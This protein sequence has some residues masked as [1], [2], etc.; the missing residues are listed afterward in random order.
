MSDEERTELKGRLRKLLDNDNVFIPGVKEMET[1]E[2][3]DHVQAQEHQANASR[4]IKPREL[5]KTPL[6]QGERQ[7]LKEFIDRRDNG[8]RIY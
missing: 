8:K 4:N 6:S 3:R 1:T 2:I 5:R 7:H